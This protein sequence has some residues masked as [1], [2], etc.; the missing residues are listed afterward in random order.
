MNIESARKILKM[1]TGS[2]K[3]LLETCSAIWIYQDQIGEP[4]ALLASGMHSEGYINLSL[5]LQFPN[6]CQLL[7]TKLVHRLEDEIH[8]IGAIDAVASPSSAAITLGH[9]MARQLNAM[10]VFT[11]KKDNKQIWTG[12]FNLPKRARVLQV[13]DSITALTSIRKS[14]KAV[15]DSN[16]EIN[17]IEINGKTVVAT[18]VH[19]PN[20]LPVIYSDYQVISLMNLQIKS[21]SSEECP[22]C[23]R[24]SL[25]LKPKENWLQ[26]SRYYSSKRR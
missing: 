1:K 25:V 26:F 4:H 17:F 3:R 10:F 11:E 7:A 18:I 16:P 2:L 23:E 20:R 5:V 14:K 13:D 15:L 8:I 6:L 12:R 19:R 21:W 22:I 9:E 24:G